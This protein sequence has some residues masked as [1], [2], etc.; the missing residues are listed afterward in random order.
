VINLFN[1]LV[2]GIG[3]EFFEGK[4]C[5][6]KMLKGFFAEKFCWWKMLKG[7]FAEKF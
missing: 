7:F 3:N 4:F 6:W 5:W 1:E 2:S